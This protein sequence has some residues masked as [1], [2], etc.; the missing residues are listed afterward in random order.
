MSIKLPFGLKNGDIIH[1]SEVESGLACGCICPN[2][3]DRL[4]ARKGTKNIHH[5]AHVNSDCNK[6]LE[7]ALHLLAKKILKENMEIL[8]PPVSMIHA[9]DFGHDH[10]LTGSKTI[11]NSQKVKF[12]KVILEKKMGDIVS[13]VVGYFRNKP[14]LIEIKVTH[15]IDEEKKNKIENM[16][17]SCIEI[18]LSDLKQEKLINPNE[19]KELIINKILNKKWIYNAKL[20]KYLKQ[21]NNSKT[22]QNVKQR[23]IKTTQN[24]QKEREDIWINK[25]RACNY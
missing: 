21:E 2:C 23:K 12:D 7:T 9:D 25:G 10:L 19:I 4:K 16:K 1:I 24:K 14:L 15:G 20:E 8:L 11:Y 17:I 18:N 3:R 5:F 6:G 22:E 13:D